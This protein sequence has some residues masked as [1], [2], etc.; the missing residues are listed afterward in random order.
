MS[1]RLFCY[2]YYI[3]HSLKV[4]LFLDKQ[5]Q[6]LCRFFEKS[7]PDINPLYA[8]YSILLHAFSICPHL[9]KIDTLEDIKIRKDMNL[10]TNFIN[11]IY[12]TIKGDSQESITAVIH[13]DNIDNAEGMFRDAGT[14]MHVL[15]NV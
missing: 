10:S 5:R 7:A 1:F 13:R 11:M 12:N 2:K 6:V 14:I 9:F 4:N 15:A 3:T 8:I